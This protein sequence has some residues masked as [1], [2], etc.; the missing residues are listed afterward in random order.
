MALRAACGRIKIKDTTH[1]TLSQLWWAR[2]AHT[3][4][5]V[6]EDSGAVPTREGGAYATPCPKVCMVVIPR[7]CS[8]PTADRGHPAHQIST[9]S[10]MGY[11]EHRL[12][13]MW[14][15]LSNGRTHSS[16]RRWSGAG[17]NRWLDKEDAGCT[18]A[19]FQLVY[20]MH[21]PCSGQG[22]MTAPTQPRSCHS[23]KLFYGAARMANIQ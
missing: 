22:L 11:C 7:I 12:G 15:R 17:D 2:A 10:T 1:R 18:L 5:L 16:Q 19:F 21:T 20:F 23:L 8:G 4:S 9:L 13:R 3:P 6:H 14:A